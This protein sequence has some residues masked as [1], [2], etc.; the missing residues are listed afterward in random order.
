[1]NATLDLGRPVQDA[2]ACPTCGLGDRP[3]WTDGAVVACASCMSRRHPD[4]VLRF[5]TGAKTTA[6]AQATLPGMAT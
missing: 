2:G 5:R 4:V 3:V 6:A 1:V